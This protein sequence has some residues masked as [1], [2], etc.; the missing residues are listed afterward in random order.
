MNIEKRSN[1]KEVLFT[2]S[3]KKTQLPCNEANGTFPSKETNNTISEKDIRKDN[4]GNIIQK[5]KKLHRLMF[6][7]KIDNLENKLVE[8]VYIDSFKNY[9]RLILKLQMLDN[10]TCRACNII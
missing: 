3:S 5:G 2:Q 7:D 10:Y 8:V 6:K 4:C 1:I 9:N